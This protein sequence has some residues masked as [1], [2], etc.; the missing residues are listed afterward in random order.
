MLDN[1]FQTQSHLH[2]ST[3]NYNKLTKLGALTHEH[4]QAQAGWLE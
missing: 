1:Y 4:R 3:L 2:R